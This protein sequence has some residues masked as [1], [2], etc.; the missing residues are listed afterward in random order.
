MKYGSWS[1]LQ[2]TFT[3]K[4]F[5]FKVSQN[6]ERCGDKLSPEKKKTKNKQHQQS[7]EGNDNQFA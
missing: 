5:F 1:D 2:N 6:V 3:L 4:I 7:K